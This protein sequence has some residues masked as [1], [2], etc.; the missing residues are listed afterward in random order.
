MPATLDRPD[1]SWSWA[2][3]GKS[4]KIRCGIDGFAFVSMASIS[5]VTIAQ[6]D[7]VDC[8]DGMQFDRSRSSGG[9]GDAASGAMVTESYG[10]TLAKIAGGDDPRRFDSRSSLMSVE[11]QASGAGDR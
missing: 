11:N 8:L 6:I 3:G 7:A 2:A 10:T 1:W 5:I 9:V 4:Q